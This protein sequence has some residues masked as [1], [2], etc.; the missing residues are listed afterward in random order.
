MNAQAKHFITCGMYAFTDKLR[1]A[2]QS[3]FCEFMLMYKSGDHIEPIIRF[4]TDFDLLRNPAMFLGH[5]CGYPLMRFLRSDCYPV[6]VPLFDVDGCEGKFY[7]SH[8]VVSAD[9]EIDKLS[10]CQ[11]GIVAIN[12][13]DSNSGMNVLRHAIASLG[14]PP[15]FFSGVIVSGSHLNSLTSVANGETDV[16]AI[17]SVSFALIKDEW[18]ELIG[19]VKTIGYSEVSCGL[20]LVIPASE[21]ENLDPQGITQALNQALSRLSDSHRDTL[22]LA[23]FEDVALDDYQ[24]I[25]DLETYAAQTGYTELT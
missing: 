10:E 16:A 4:E 7:S 3:L 1:N 17:D 24:S 9:S 11:N 15:P 19:R 2:W 6:C 5:T 14:N 23:G 13:Q 20:P 22:H 8:I 21:R 18:P 12:D 25:I